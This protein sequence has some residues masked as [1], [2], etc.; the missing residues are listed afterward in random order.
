[1]KRP[2]VQGAGDAGP[3][4]ENPPTHSKATRRYGG[5]GSIDKPGRPSPIGEGHEPEFKHTRVAPS[6]VEHG[7]PGGF[8]RHTYE[9]TSGALGGME[10][11]RRAR[12]P[13]ATPEQEQY[14]RQFGYNGGSKGCGKL[15]G[16]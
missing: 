3:R 13:Y 7:Y 4:R 5:L 12:H 10:Y 16:A 15:P 1:M 9:H 11:G 2:T 14:E 6:S 8:H